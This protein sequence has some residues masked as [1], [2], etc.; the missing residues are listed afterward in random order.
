MA[1]FPL[2]MHL[3]DLLTVIGMYIDVQLIRIYSICN[4]QQIFAENY[5][6]PMS[7]NYSTEQNHSLVGFRASTS[8]MRNLAI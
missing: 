1:N 5:Q 8:Q 7:F 2:K 3:L 4:F 6:L